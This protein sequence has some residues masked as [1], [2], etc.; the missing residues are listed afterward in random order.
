MFDG[1]NLQY[2][3]VRDATIEGVEFESY[4]DAQSWFAG[5]G[6]HRIRGTNEDT[7]TGLMTIPADQVTLTAGF[8]AFDNK[9]TAGARTRFVAKQDRFEPGEIRAAQ[10]ADSYTV[11]DLFG[12]YQVNDKLTVNANIDNLFDET[13]RQ[14]LDQYNSPGFNAR[15]GVTMRLGAQ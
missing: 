7:G 2:Q 13:Y 4:Y 3:N 11:V 9:L 10:F 8:R 15:V 6:A 14:H 5:I 12:E 1:V